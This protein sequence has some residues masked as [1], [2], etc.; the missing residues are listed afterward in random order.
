M[1]VAPKSMPIVLNGSLDLDADGV[2]KL[3]LNGGYKASV[4]FEIKAV[5]DSVG[6]AA[7]PDVQAILVSIFGAGFGR[8]V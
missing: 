6:L 2:V 1:S 8:S 4:T 3:T 7:D 5:A